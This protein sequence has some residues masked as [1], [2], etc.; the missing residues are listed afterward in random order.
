[1]AQLEAAPRTRDDNV[2]KIRITI[3]AREMQG[4]NVI[5]ES[6]AKELGLEWEPIP[7]NIRMADNRT[8]LPRGL[9]KHAKIKVGSMEY[10]VN[11]VVIAMQTP[12]PDSYQVLL[13]RPWL[14]DAKVKHDWNRD[15]ISLRKGNKKTYIE[16]GQ[17]KT[18]RLP[19][20]TPLHAE[21]YNMAEGLEEDEEEY[22]LQQNP[23][24]TPLFM[25]HLDKLLQK[26]AQAPGKL[27]NKKKQ[28]EPEDLE[29]QA[30][31]CQC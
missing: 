1:M 15:R 10:L 18:T 7:F 2:A 27:V 26:E 6:I 13:G 3:G 20:C 21:T 19:Q 23:N 24:L 8:V 4:V 14:R 30:R 25:V 31:Q 22:L 29:Q 9:V 12:T 17:N 16:F 11:L 5:I 28:K